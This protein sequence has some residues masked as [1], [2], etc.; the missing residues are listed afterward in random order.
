M[1]VMDPL[2][3]FLRRLEENPIHYR[4]NKVRD[5]IMVEVAIP[6]QR[7]EVEFFP[8]GSIE[9]EKFITTGTIEDASVLDALFS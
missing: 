8:D 5:A 3:A 1:I 2:L 9:V 4:L 7:W 6:G